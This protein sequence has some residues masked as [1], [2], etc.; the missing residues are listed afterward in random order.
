MLG[1]IVYV[2]YFVYRFLQY[3]NEWKKYECD[4]DWSPQWGLIIQ[5]VNV[6]FSFVSTVLM[7]SNKPV[8]EERNAA[9]ELE[10]ERM[11]NDNNSNQHGPQ[12]SPAENVMYDIVTRSKE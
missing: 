5:A 12:S 3:Y 11:G 10:L 8:I 2:S 6:V 4:Y 7:F 9:V 1:Q